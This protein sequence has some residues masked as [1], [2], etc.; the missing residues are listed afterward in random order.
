MIGG[1]TARRVAGEL[2]ADAG[3][4]VILYLVHGLLHLCGYDDLD[5]EQVVEMRRR[6]AELLELLAV[7]ARV[8]G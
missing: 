3:E 2:G 6:E 4:E 1:E 5:D 7:T 8:D